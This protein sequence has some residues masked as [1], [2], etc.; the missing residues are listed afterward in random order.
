MKVN[1]EVDLLTGTRIVTVTGHHVIETEDL[2]ILEEHRIVG[3]TTTVTEMVVVG[4]G[5]GIDT[6]TEAG[7]IPLDMVEEEGHPEVRISKRER[8]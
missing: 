7:L 8:L 1:T 5:E 6:G 3:P 2:G 4:T